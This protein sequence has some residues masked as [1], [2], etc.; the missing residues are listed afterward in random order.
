VTDL[1]NGMLVDHVSLG[2]GKI[3]AL[4]P[5]AVHVFF[6]SND[7]RFATKLRLPIAS[8]MLSPS[9]SHNAWLSG[10][11]F[12]LDPS[13]HRYGLAFTWLTHAEA[14][15]RFREAFP[16]GFQDPR[17]LGEGR[18][19]ERVGR[20]RGAHQAY[21]E[22]LGGGE[23]E[24]LLAA[25]DVGALVER[26]LAVEKHVRVLQR[27]E[28]ERSSL[29]SVLAAP[30]RA[31]AYF[32]ALFPHL[33]A[34]A[35]EQA[36]FEALAAAAGARDAEESAWSVVTLLPFVARPDV[37]MVLRPQ[38]TCDVARRLGL[39]L[40]YDAAPSWRAYQ[41]LL[42]CTGS[43]LEKLR[44]LGA[45]DHMDVEAFMYAATAKHQRPRVPARTA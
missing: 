34:P 18:E 1:E 39:E 26:A 37:H 21:E 10:L 2:L 35:P 8:S 30:E 40:E 41:S 38:L 12:T 5:K 44:E 28:D 45:R 27:K 17:Y 16:Q 32:A 29:A 25:G 31:R 22:A 42:R 23:G 20:W 9:T 19:R 7:G 36:L 33:S 24:R 13:T 11:E 6:A 14:V 15:A 3:V 4:E 43:L